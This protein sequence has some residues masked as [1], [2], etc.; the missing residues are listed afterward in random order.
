MTP[1]LYLITPNKLPPLDGFAEALATTLGTG[2]VACVLF[3]KGGLSDQAFAQAVALLLPLV[4]GRDVAF[5]LEDHLELAAEAGCDGIHLSDAEA[6]PGARSRLGQDAIV[7]VFCGTS[8]D[9]AMETADKGAD[10]V[11]FSAAGDSP[12]SLNLDLLSWWQAFTTVPCVAMP[13]E[14]GPELTGEIAIDA[15]PALAR[16]GADFIALGSAIWDHP[17][18]PEAAINAYKTAVSKA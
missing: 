18:G 16:A 14:S 2:D 7:G 5:L 15:V 17:K 9:L 1:Q 8:P 12:E 10:Y 4:Q 11:A 6:Y 13:P 3:R